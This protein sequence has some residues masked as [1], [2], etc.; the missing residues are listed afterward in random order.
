M[1]ACAPTAPQG[2][3]LQD[4]GFAPGTRV[5]LVPEPENEVDPYAIGIWDLERQ[6]Q[7]VRRRPVQPGL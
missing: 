2:N 3:A 1:F 5:A 4:D 6:V 7:A